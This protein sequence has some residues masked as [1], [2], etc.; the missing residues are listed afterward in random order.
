M[1]NV[2]KVRSTS[3]TVI[4]HLRE[5]LFSSLAGHSSPFLKAT[6]APNCQLPEHVAEPIA[7]Y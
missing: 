1:R 7:N 3:R 6:A 4:S 2:K 5:R